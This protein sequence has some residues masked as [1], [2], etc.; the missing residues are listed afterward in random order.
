MILF[1]VNLYNI[2]RLKN[3]LTPKMKII[4]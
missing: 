1:S 2:F 4:K 3:I